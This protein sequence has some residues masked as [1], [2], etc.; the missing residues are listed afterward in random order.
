VRILKLKLHNFVSYR[1]THEFD[2]GP[3]DGKN[4]YFIAGENG[5]GKT[6]LSDAI[7]WV[8]YG[9]VE[10]FL[11]GSTEL[12]WEERPIC[13]SEDFKNTGGELNFNASLL[14]NYA[15]WDG[16]YKMYV[17]ITFTHEGSTYILHRESKP[18]VSGTIPE[19]DNH[20]ETTVSL[21]VDGKASP[22]ERV[23]DEI[24]SIMPKEISRFFFIQGDSIQ[25]FASISYGPQFG[26][27]LREEINSILG[28]PL[29]T[30]SR[31]DFQKIQAVHDDKLSE[32]K[33]DQTKDKALKKKI[34]KKRLLI[35]SHR[36]ELKAENEERKK[37]KLDLG[38]I[39][40]ELKKN[41]EITS[42]I[43]EAEIKE[44]A[45]NTLTTQLETSYSARREENS[46]LWLISLKDFVNSSIST[47]EK[48]EEKQKEATQL[49]AI[50]NARIDLSRA[51]LDGANSTCPVCDESHDGASAD[52]AIRILIE[53]RM[54]ESEKFLVH[55][56]D[57][58]QS[59]NFTQMITQLSDFKTPQTES[60]IIRTETGIARLIIEID[61]LQ[62]DAKNIRNRVKAFGDSV[63]KIGDLQRKEI[64][65]MRLVTDSE[66]T[67]ESIQ[68]AIKDERERLSK[69]RGKEKSQDSAKAQSERLHSEM[70][71]WLIESF[72]GV[73]RDYE[74][75]ARKSVQKV[76][77]KAFF[78]MDDEPEKFSKLTITDSYG[79]ALFNSNG[80]RD[81][82]INSG[83]RQALAVAL[84]EG[85][86]S[87]SGLRFPTVF[88][89]P[90]S[91]ISAG[92]KTRMADYFWKKPQGQVMLFSHSGG[93]TMDQV[94]ERYANNL[95]QCWTLEYMDD[96]TR[97]T[98][99]T[100]I[101]IKKPSS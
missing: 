68:S 55:Q 60:D 64:S 80:Q 35:K 28:L 7:L 82:N 14:T 2:F 83:T 11:M 22:P 93:Y 87:T 79:V 23:Q 62:I 47:T 78:E 26:G 77:E 100:E 5:R 33:D 45:A 89:N 51:I 56:I 101:T 13:N 97:L 70:Y 8:L 27:D 92:V 49:G 75:T 10:A 15:W 65:V 44:D 84:F 74:I 63:K 46:N 20:M 98:K 94:T 85:L 54:A 24:N 3:E 57:G 32:I 41:R 21:T 90:G 39:Q 67:I 58:D 18:R 71:K 12:F 17:Q 37:Y 72:Q 43:K 31:T 9:K 34:K 25:Q 40:S 59:R 73:L 61:K 50:A 86:R 76:A 38:R 6:A 69:L 1:G 42:L 91:A 30:K 29:L 66:G 4:G 99:V 36:G 19:E 96:D 16:D 53:D 95:Q 48:L 81:I 52:E 88:D